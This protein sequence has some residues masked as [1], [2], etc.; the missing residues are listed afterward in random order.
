MFKNFISSC[1]CIKNQIQIHNI[2]MHTHTH[3]HSRKGNWFLRQQLLKEV[4][5]D[6]REREAGV[7]WC[8]MGEKVD[9]MTTGS[10]ITDVKDN[11]EAFRHWKNER[12][13][14]VIKKEPECQKIYK[15]LRPIKDNAWGK[16]SIHS[17]RQ[18]TEGINE[19]EN[20]HTEAVQI[21]CEV[22][23]SRM[24]IRRASKKSD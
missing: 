10:M 15:D 22:L 21:K 16:K 7:C 20:N 14:Q 6:G 3:T 13:W 12:W 11:S 18:E 5:G 2:Y 19:R 9:K 1:Y 23:T 8:V 4:Y 17:G 24:E